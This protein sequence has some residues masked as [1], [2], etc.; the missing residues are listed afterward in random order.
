MSKEDNVK[1]PIR[2]KAKPTQTT[3]D[4]PEVVEGSGVK[5]ELKEKVERKKYV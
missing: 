5:D 4:L 2:K 1:E 3:S